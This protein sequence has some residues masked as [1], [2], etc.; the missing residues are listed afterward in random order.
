MKPTVSIITVN[1]NGLFMTM[2]LLRSLSELSLD[3]LEVIVVDNASSYNPEAEI[4]M[5]FPDVKVVVSDKNLGFAGGNNLGIKA[6]TGD[7]LF[8]LNNDTELKEDIITPM[9]KLMS[10]NYQIGALCPHICDFDAPHHLQYAGFTDINPLS[11][12]NSLHDNPEGKALPY[13]TAF[14][15]G[16]AMMIRR[17]TIDKVGPMPEEYFLYYEELDWGYQIR[18]AGYDIVVD[19]RFMVYHKESAS[20]GLQSPMKTFYHS[21]NRLLYMRRN[22]SGLSLLI[23]MTYFFLLAVPK[24]LLSYMIHSEWQHVRALLSGLWLF[25]LPTY[26]KPLENVPH[27]IPTNVLTHA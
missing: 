12:R 8:F 1:Y 17:S 25:R 13:L 3:N 6:A 18:E 19:P 4:N 20:V 2:E 21:R 16:A 23:F 11:G 27:P 9:V 22:V 7:Y 24:S 26:K 10:L 5:H 14:P 15:H